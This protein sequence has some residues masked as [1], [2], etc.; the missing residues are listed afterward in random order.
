MSEETQVRENFVSETAKVPGRLA[1]IP[2]DKI[3]ENKITL[4]G[5]NQ[6]SPEFITL[7]DSVRSHGVLQPIQVRECVDGETGETR[8]G[9]INGLQRL[10]ASK[11]C[12]YDQ[13]DAVIRD[14]S[15]LEVLEQ[16][17][18]LNA[19][20]VP[21]KGHEYA[22][23]L[24]QMLQYDPT[25]SIAA[26]AARVGMGQLWVKQRLQLLDLSDDIGALVDEG[27][28]TI[29]NAVE[30]STLPEEIQQDYVANA[31]TMPHNE[32]AALVKERKDAIRKAKLGQRPDEPVFEATPVLRKLVDIKPVQ[33]NIQFA[34]EQCNIA[35]CNTA[36]D[37]FLAAILW[38]LSLDPTSVAERRSIFDKRLE[39][40][41]KKKETAAASQA[42]RKLKVN[43]IKTEASRHRIDL[44][45]KGEMT[46]EQ[47]EEAVKKFMEQKL[48]EL[49]KAEEASK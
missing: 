36:V 6:E 14:S 25:M 34:T 10:T 47:I 40:D 15:D 13:I 8:Y 4:R 37:G 29:V 43:E 12:G 32:F 35:S 9:L 21:T 30:L 16:Q 44:I 2:I 42:A 5:V 49:K 1:R 7:V 3:F 48:E 22:K 39:D 19:N 31:S 41:K 46:T 27:R 17:V 11:L 24:R 26:L 33:A 18:L 20:V 28:I 38:V 23:L 45:N